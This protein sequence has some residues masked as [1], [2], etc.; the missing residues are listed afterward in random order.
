MG[1]ISPPW[2]NAAIESLMGPVKSEGVHA[3]V[4]ATRDEASLDLLE[5]IEVIYNRARIHTALVD[6]SPVEFEEVNWPD[7]ES[8]PKA[9]QKASMESG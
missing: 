8:H 6:P 2:D 9:A 4:Y 7:D 1:S 3:R 5:Y